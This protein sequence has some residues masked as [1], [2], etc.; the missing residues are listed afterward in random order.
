LQLQQSR[1]L[2]DKG[3]DMPAIEQAAR[4]H[5]RRKNAF[6]QQ[7]R[8]WKREALDTAIAHLFEAQAVAR[9]TPALAA[10]VV[11]RCCLQLSLAAKRRG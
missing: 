8:H 10:S 11:S 1:A 9:K 7:V 3:K 2:L 6:Q 5:F 4:V